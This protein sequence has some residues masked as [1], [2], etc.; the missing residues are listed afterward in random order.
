MMSDKKEITLPQAADPWYTAM[1]KGLLSMVEKYN[2]ALVLLA[3][4]KKRIEELEKNASGN[5]N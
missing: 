3:E 5:G 4:Q 1:N 2:A